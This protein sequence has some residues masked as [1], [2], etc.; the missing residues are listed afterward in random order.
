MTAWK[1]FKY[2]D[3]SGPY[4]PAFGLNTKMYGV[5][6]RIQSEYGKIRTR[7]NS[8]FGH[9]SRSVFSITAAYR[10]SHQRL[11]EARS[12][13]GYNFRKAIFQNSLGEDNLILC[14]TGN[15]K[16]FFRLVDRQNNDNNNAKFQGRY[17]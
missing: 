12:L 6:L 14:C 11:Q 1:V 13:Q 2:G 4:F 5:N 9:F 8:V 10:S 7:K 15:L 3:F 16:N 17:I